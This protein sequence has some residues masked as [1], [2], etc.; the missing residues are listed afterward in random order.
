MMSFRD[1]D[2][3]LLVDVAGTSF[4]RAYRRDMVGISARLIRG[5]AILKRCFLR[6]E[7]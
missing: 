1:W 4:L 3:V 6:D 5:V 2:G 7:D